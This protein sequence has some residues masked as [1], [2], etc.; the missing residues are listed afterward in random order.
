MNTNDSQTSTFKVGDWH[1]DPDS[2]R[3]QRKYEEAL[4]A[5]DKPC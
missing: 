3:L 4:S 5:S 2:G 1:A